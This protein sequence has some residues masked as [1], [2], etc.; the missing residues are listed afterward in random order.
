M[1]H[2][3][4]LTVLALIA[5]C[6]PDHK[7]ETAT[8]NADSASIA[9][10]GAA[11]D[12]MSGQQSAAS[13]IKD[14]ALA[15][16]VIQKALRVRPGDVV[17]IV[18]GT[19]LMPT[20]EEL[21]IKTVMA[22][23]YS[24]ILINSDRVTR[25]TLKDAPEEFLGRPSTYFADWLRK[26]T[27]YVGLPTSADPK[28]TFAD[29]PEARMAKWNA[30]FQAVYDMLNGSSLRGAYIDYPSKGA[31]E[32]VGMS[33]SAYNRMQLSAIA[34]DPETMSRSG[35][36]LESRFHKGKSVHITSPAGTNITITLAGRSGIIDAGTLPPGAEKEKLF[37]K[38]WL[39]LPGGGYGVAPRE[40]SAN[41]VVVTP[42]DQCK[43]GPLR[44]ARY[45]VTK[46]A[47]TKVS[48]KTGQACLD[49]LLATYGAT[50]RQIGSVWIGLNPELKVVEE[51]GDYRPGNAAGLVTVWLGDNTLMGG[52][53]KVPGGSGF[54]LPIV[55]ATV[56]VDDETVVKDG[57]LAGAELAVTGN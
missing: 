14:E 26:T 11:T 53:N 31:A 40:G 56:T 18:G 28:A 7:T 54:G 20:M 50:F 47:V 12:S 52:S 37:S 35:Q 25:A 36:A 42:K 33:Y 27:V 43:F 24:N 19:Y 8:V 45:E 22:G 23:G 2:F 30:G 9:A 4:T 3:A 1:R 10:S 5:A 39:S 48:A 41:G 44:D 15:T 21:A 57:K 16:Q 55:G 6:R 13:T 46:G 49:E 29:V 32:A 34:A 38:R 51:G 17:M